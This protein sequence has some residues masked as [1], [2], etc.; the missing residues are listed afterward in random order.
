[1]G[2]TPH[3]VRRAKMLRAVDPT[4]ATSHMASIAAEIRQLTRETLRVVGWEFELDHRSVAWNAPLGSILAIPPR[5][6]VSRPLGY[7]GHAR[8]VTSA[9]ERH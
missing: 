4:D 5:D 3:A 2:K 8:P 9:C 1:M 7:W 6:V